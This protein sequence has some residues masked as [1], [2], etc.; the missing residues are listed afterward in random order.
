MSRKMSYSLILAILFFVSATN[1]SD[2]PNNNDLPGIVTNQ[3]T[4]EKIDGVQ[5]IINDTIHSFSDST[6][7]IIFESFDFGKRPEKLIAKKMGFELASWVYNNSE[8]LIEMRETTIRHL[9]GQVLLSDGT[10]LSAVEIEFFG[11]QVQSTMTG[12][13]GEFSFEIPIEDNDI[14]PNRF[15]IDGHRLQMSIV[16]DDIESATIHLK[17]VAHEMSMPQKVITVNL[18]SVRG[19]PT[20]EISVIING[21]YYKSDNNGSLLIPANSKLSNIHIQGYKVL[22][23]DT[24]L[25]SNQIVLTINKSTPMSQ[26]QK[27]VLASDSIVADTLI[28]LAQ[29]PEQD[30]MAIQ[31]ELAVSQGLDSSKYFF[32][33][34]EGELKKQGDFINSLKDSVSRLTHISHLD[35]KHLLIQLEELN[36]SIVLSEEAF[37]TTKNASSELILKLRTILEDKDRE[38]KDI[39][40]AKDALDRMNKENI[41]TFTWIL[42]ALILMLLMSHWVNRRFKK[43]KIVIEKTK[44]QLLEAQEMAKVTN[45]VYDYKKKTFSYS[46]NFF[47]TLRISDTKRK[48]AIQNSSDEYIPNELIDNE[49]RSRVLLNWK[50]MLAAQEPIHIR[51]KGKTDDNGTLYIDMNSQL[52]FTTSGKKESISVSL[53][54]VTEQTENELKLINALKELESTSKAKEHFMASM[55]HEIRTPLNAIIGLADHLLSQKY[56]D[57]QL[58]N[59]KAIEFSSKHLLSLVNDMLDF[60]RIRARKLKLNIEVFDIINLTKG[61]IKSMSNQASEKGL[62]LE[63][64]ISLELPQYLMGDQLRITQV[65]MNL[66]GNGIKFTTTGSITL[67]MKLDRKTPDTVYVGFHIKDTGV[68]I[69]Q[70]KLHKIFEGFEQENISTARK[71][72]GSGLGLTIS[73]EL[74]NLMGGEL[75]V[76]SETGKGSEF[77]FVLP[78]KIAKEKEKEKDNELSTEI[79][80]RKTL[81]KMRVLCVEDNKINQLVL[82]Q[83][84]NKWKIIVEY[85]NNGSE[86]LEKFDPDQFD[87]I[88]MDIRLPDMDGYEVTRKLLERFPDCPTPIIALTAE[89]NEH[90]EEKF[91]AA[92]MSGFLPKPF[93]EEQLLLT[94][95]KFEKLK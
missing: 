86:A 26:S 1:K 65:L 88:F 47:K 49:D 58:E 91:I 31:A 44:E 28:Q 51:F 50:K 32:N 46:D 84:F 14:S 80:A 90:A 9:N 79:N 24:L 3:S 15:N 55:S 72:G 20:E 17:L 52:D 43:Q 39:Q 56:L 70:D 19:T 16:N 85:A 71:Y 81:I 27:T 40:E 95:Q 18:Q 54:N 13:K 59:L 41:K 10:G 94:I 60:S 36:K 93:K 38:I 67:E 73:K 74:V 78:L 69:H 48:K 29:N 23:I 22:A 82:S 75:Q 35:H 25:K 68:G 11:R 87:L 89:V 92:G 37:K 76:K 77:F 2:I 61:L 64:A 30:S 6:G 33:N 45:M 63:E 53:Q 7:Y 5:V 42:L 57:G 21:E 83:Y 4:G 66:I 62:Q 34:Q 12:N 8:L